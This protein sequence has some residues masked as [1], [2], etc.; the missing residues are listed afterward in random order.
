MYSCWVGWCNSTRT[1]CLWPL[2]VSV[3]LCAAA[4]APERRSDISRCAI[5]ALISGTV[6]CFMTACVAG[7]V[8]TL[9][10][11]VACA[12]KRILIISTIFCWS[13]LLSCRRNPVYTS[14][15]MPDLPG[16]PV[17]LLCGGKQLRPAHVLFGRL[18]LVQSCSPVLPPDIVLPLDTEKLPAITITIRLQW[19]A[20]LK[21]IE[22]VCTAGSDMYVS[23]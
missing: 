17:Q 21:G 11:R 6:A 5:R 13:C 2:S 16:G 9:V 4:L 7:S 23:V 3:T 18:S 12:K 20:V 10:S 1:F 22:C 19:A 15:W 8:R 14:V